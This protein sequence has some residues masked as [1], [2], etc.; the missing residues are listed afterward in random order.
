MI[1]ETD[2][3]D[4]ICKSQFVDHKW[5]DVGNLQCVDC[6]LRIPE[7]WEHYVPPYDDDEENYFVFSH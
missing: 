6:G 5:E 3:L 1:L 7:Y 4:T 2:N